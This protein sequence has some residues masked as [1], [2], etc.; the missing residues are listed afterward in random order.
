[1]CFSRSI[2]RWHKADFDRREAELAMAQVRTDNAEREAKRTEQLLPSKA[3]SKEE[4]DAREAR[5]AEARAGC[6]PPRPPAIHPTRS[7]SRYRGPLAR[8][9]AGSAAPSSPAGNYVSG[10]AGAARSSPPSSPSIPSTSTPTWMSR[11]PAFQRLS[12]NGSLPR[13]PGNV[14]RSNCNSPTKRFHQQGLRGIARQPGGSA[15]RQHRP[16]RRVSQSDGRIV[17]GLFARIRLPGAAGARVA[18][19]GDRHRHRSGAEIRTDPDRHQHHGLSPRETGSGG[20]WQAGGSAKACAPAKSR[21]QWPRTVRPG[22][23][24]EPTRGGGDGGRQVPS[25]DRSAL[26]VGDSANRRTT[27]STSPSPSAGPFRSNSM[28]FSPFLHPPS[29]LR[30]RIVGADPAAGPD[31]HV[32]LPI[33]EYPEVV[34]PT[35]VV[36]ANYPGANPKTIAETVAAPLEQ[37]INGVE[38][39]LYMFSQATSDGV[40]TLTVTFKLGTTSTT[41]RCRCRTASPRPAQAARGS[42]PSRR[43]HHQAIARSHD[44]GAS[45]CRRTVATTRST[46]AT[47]PRCR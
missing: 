17:P 36:M 30:R 35:I 32:R 5:Y 16:A 40:M 22:M 42:P 41:P 27:Y 4:A 13:T 43:H 1:M 19:R 31:R 47:T 28:K 46:C 11:A 21:R 38:N 15:D 10:L 26:A 34:P 18:D 2:P 14:C 3:I 6:S 33:S 37:A 29:D 20:R 24:V 25:A 9:T 44:G 39:S 8:S 12:R 7:G 45:A 23:P